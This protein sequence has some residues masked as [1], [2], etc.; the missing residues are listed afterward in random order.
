MARMKLVPHRPAKKVNMKKPHL[1]T[2]FTRTGP[3]ERLLATDVTRVKRLMIGTAAFFLA[4]FIIPGRLG[5][6]WNASPSL[7]VGIYIESAE[8]SSLVEFCPAEPAASFAAARGYRDAGSCPD[9]ATPLMKPVVARVGDTVDFSAQG[10]AVNRRLLPNTAPRSAD[11]QGRPLQHFAFGRH[12]VE[13][14]TVWVASTYN[15]RSFDSR[16][17][18]PIPEASVR[19][20]LRP[21]LTE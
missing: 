10:V 15:P 16:Y 1:R 12:V 18:G 7:P 9:G 2:P 6:R 13:K 17:F 14:G 19:A 3:F 21:L 5:I 11:T 20:H 4:L 8:P